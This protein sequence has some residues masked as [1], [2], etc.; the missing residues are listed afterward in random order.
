MVGVRRIRRADVPAADRAGA[1]MAA[2]AV[3][4]SAKSLECAAPLITSRN[5]VAR[6]WNEFYLRQHAPFRSSV[7]G[8]S[9]RSAKKPYT[10]KNSES[11]AMMRELES[12]HQIYC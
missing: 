7:Y 1:G 4:A 12:D 2:A 3:D 9:A 5:V 11:C 10:N 8:F 6:V